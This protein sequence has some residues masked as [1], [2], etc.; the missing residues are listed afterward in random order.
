MRAISA[1]SSSARLADAGFIRQH[2]PAIVGASRRRAVGCCNAEPRPT[3]GVCV[4]SALN[5]PRSATPRKWTP[6]RKIR[7][8]GSAPSRSDA[9]I[10]EQCPHVHSTRSARL[11]GAKASASHRRCEVVSFGE[12][13]HRRAERRGCRAARQAR[14]RAAS[15]SPSALQRTLAAAKKRNRH[16]T[17]SAR[18]RHA[19]SRDARAGDGVLGR[20][21]AT[22]DHQRRNSSPV[23]A[24][25][26]EQHAGRRVIVVPPQL[27]AQR[28]LGLPAG[29]N[30]G[31]QDQRGLR[32]FVDSRRTRNATNA[33]KVGGRARS[34]ARYG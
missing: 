8:R 31:C 1:N 13:L 28:R 3:N 16:P 10:G 14:R 26:V 4:S 23:F 19:Q 20:C 17:T 11:R 6:A 18:S 32:R 29:G 2:Q 21:V 22:A 25:S 27:L 9:L 24:R 5:W 34:G 12:A 30:V 7:R 33:M 15:L